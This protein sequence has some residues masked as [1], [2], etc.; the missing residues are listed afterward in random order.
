MNTDD[1]FKKIIGDSILDRGYE[2][3]VTVL[4]PQCQFPFLPP[5]LRYCSARGLLPFYVSGIVLIY[6]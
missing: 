1:G 5:R 3:E 4:P 2:G 6:S